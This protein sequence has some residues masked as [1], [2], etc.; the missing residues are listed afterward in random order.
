MSM[1]LP[2]PFEI[3]AAPTPDADRASPSR[4]A[5]RRV[6]VAE[7]AYGPSEPDESLFPLDRLRARD[8]ELLEIV[9][10][11]HRDAVFRFIRK[12]VRS[13]AEAEDLTHDTFVQALRSIERFEGRSSLRTWL[14]GIARHV[15]LRFYRFGDRWMIGPGSAEESGEPA[16]DARIERRLDAARALERCDLAL[17]RL[18]GEENRSIFHLRYADGAPIRHIADRTGKSRDAVKASLRRSRLAIERALPPPEDRIA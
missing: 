3:E 18:R 10:A 6:V 2:D 13:D 9:Y 5:L 11:Q 14:L 7:R 8:P 17:E 15:C 16:F 12:R 4:P 1:P